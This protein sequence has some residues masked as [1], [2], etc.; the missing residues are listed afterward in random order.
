MTDSIL[1]GGTR[2]TIVSLIGTTGAAALVFAYQAIFELIAARWS[3]AAARGAI[4][5]VLAC[6]SYLIVRYRDD[7]I[8]TI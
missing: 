7:L 8:D 5:G 3:D 2:A 6:A 1:R 4:G